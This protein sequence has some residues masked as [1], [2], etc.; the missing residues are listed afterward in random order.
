MKKKIEEYLKQFGLRETWYSLIYNLSKDERIEHNENI[1]ENLLKDKTFYEISDLYEYSLSFIDKLNKKKSGQYYTPEDVCKFM[2]SQINGFDNGIWCDPCCGIGNL[3]YEILSLKPEMIN[4]MQFFD[5][6]ETALFICRFLISYF[7]NV[8]FESI[9]DNFHN[10]SFLESNDVKYNYII[11]NPPYNGKEKGEDIYISFMKK[12][13]DSDGYISVTPQSFT[14]STNKSCVELKD[15]INKYKFFKIYCFD[16]I[17]GN[18]FCGKKKGIFNT[19]TSN[20]VRA[21]ITVCR[22]NENKHSITPLIRWKTE[23]REKMF[24]KVDTLLE[25]SNNIYKDKKFLK[26]FKNTEGF[27]NYGT[28][29]LGKMA[30][31]N[32]TNFVL[33]VPSTPRYFLTASKRKLNRSSYHKIYFNSEDDLNKAY[34]TLN[35]SYSYWWWRVAD[36]GMTLS[37]SVLNKIKINENMTVDK[38]IV[39]KLESEENTNLV[40]K[41]NAGKNNENVKHSEE[42][43]TEIDNFLGCGNI[44]YIRGNSYV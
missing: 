10:S 4:T 6:D 42:L 35:S 14:N 29:E 32:K 23:E 5:I 16:N 8:D 26:L 43:I 18:I 7:F 33:Y 9:K 3:A 11:M 38:S 12:A 41:L 20:S 31:K 17:P 13:S 27:I 22:N 25:Y 15:K 21:A 39:S 40:N 30:S 1:S 2:A 28:K 24:Q 34:I 36:G 19:N 37:L 44:S